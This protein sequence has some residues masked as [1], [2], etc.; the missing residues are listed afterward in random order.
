M[1]IR[2]GSG[3]VTGPYGEKIEII[4]PQKTSNID[5]QD[6]IRHIVIL[7][8]VRYTMPSYSRSIGRVAQIWRGISL[9]IPRNHD[10]IQSKERKR[11]VKLECDVESCQGN[12]GGGLGRWRDYQ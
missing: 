3:R 2:G 6:P 12:G 11:N 10:F 8:S 9:G 4:I 7:G 1:S 5:I